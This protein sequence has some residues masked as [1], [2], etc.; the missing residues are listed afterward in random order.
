[1]RQGSD[2]CVT[3]QLQEKRSVKRGELTLAATFAKKNTGVKDHLS[4]SARDATLDPDARQRARELQSRFKFLSV[5]PEYLA[6]TQKIA[7][8][9]PL[10]RPIP[11]ELMLFRSVIEREQTPEKRERARILDDRL[12]CPR[13]P[14]WRYGVTKK[15]LEKNEE[16]NFAK[17]LQTVDDV[18][19]D[20][21]C[22]DEVDAS[23]EQEEEVVLVKEETEVEIRSPSVFERNLQVWR[24][25]WR[26]GEQS[27]V[28]L[29][30][31]D[32][33]CPPVHFPA[34]LRAYLRDLVGLSD[35]R[36]GHDEQSG[37]SKKP[38]HAQSGRKKV[39][40]VL[41]KADLVEVERQR[42]W[43]QWC[44][45][46]W[47]YGNNPPPAGIEPDVNLE[48]VPEVVCVESYKREHGA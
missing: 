43:V 30:L 45:R 15:E 31:M 11:S 10:E 18:Q 34:S 25:L 1:M 27:N 22:L 36:N 23:S 14:K 26:V 44:K 17:W 13:R 9:K 7:F 37:R 19:Y 3:A 29:V 38:K 39:V 8:E 47:L 46:W 20:Y 16:G 33:R 12:N 40:L 2:R 41:T 48:D 35:D 42:E 5:S 24:Q 28:I 21:S 32:I 6:F 4:R